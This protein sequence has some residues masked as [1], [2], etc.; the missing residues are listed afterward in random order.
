MN[1]RTL[2]ILAAF[3]VF[4]LGGV[5]YAGV[6]KI[7]GKP[8][9]HVALDGLCRRA[10]TPAPGETL[11]FSVNVIGQQVH[12]LIRRPD[13]FARC[14]RHLPVPPMPVGKF[15]HGAGKPGDWTNVDRLY[16]YMMSV[17]GCSHARLVP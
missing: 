9:P 4:A 17:S 3:A 14:V 16:R 15:D 5:A 7:V 1:R 6:S 11:M 13:P 10:V 8:G 12:C 2:I